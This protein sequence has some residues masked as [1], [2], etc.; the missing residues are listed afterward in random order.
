MGFQERQF[1]PVPALESD[2]LRVRKL[3]TKSASRVAWISCWGRWD[4]GLPG[5]RLN[6]Q[7]FY[8]HSVK[9]S[10]TVWAR[11]VFNRIQAQ[12]GRYR[13]YFRE[14]PTFSSDLMRPESIEAAMT[15]E[16]TA[17]LLSGR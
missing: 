17:L 2:P 16:T 3:E 1:V 15:W 13:A 6:K 8:F 11:D 5:K 12:N 9:M 4:S 10:E 14:A 7:V